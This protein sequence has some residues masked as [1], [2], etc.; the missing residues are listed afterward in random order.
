MNNSR[1][2]R[3]RIALNPSR[4]S[5][6]EAV[7]WLKARCTAAE[8]SRVETSAK[9]LGTTVA[10]MLSGKVLLPGD[11]QRIVDAAG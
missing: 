10:K 6:A 5:N 11:A 2:N 3:D 7:A 8:Y 4:R 1:T 9:K